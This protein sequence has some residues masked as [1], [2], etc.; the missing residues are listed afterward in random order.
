MSSAAEAMINSAVPEIS[1]PRP[2]LAVVSHLDPRYGGLSAVVPRLGLSLAESG[3]MVSLAAFTAPGEEYRPAGYDDAGL[4]FWPSSRISWL[5]SAPLRERFRRLVGAAKG[6]HIH[7]IWETSTAVA[8]RAARKAERP[9]IVSAHGMLEPWALRSK[10][11]KKKLYA[12]LLERTNLNQATCLHALTKVEAKQYRSFG[13]RGPIAVI[14]NA[15]EVPPSLSPE[16]FLDA[17][18]ELRGKRLILFLGR[19]HPK[20]GLDLLAG[21]WLR[22][23]HEYPDAVLVLA[24]PDSEGTQARIEAQLHSPGR[25]PN[26]VFAGMLQGDL[27]WSALAAAEC[28]VLPSF[29]EGLSVGVL[30]ALG[31]GLPV[32]VTRACNMPEVT[33][34]HAGWEIEP[35]PEELTQAMRDVLQRTPEQNR[36]TGLN[37]AELVRTRYHPRHIAA[38]TAALYDFVLTGKAAACLNIQYGDK[39]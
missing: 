9:Y 6:L 17:F 39:R 19:L 30:E 2:W 21:A 13:A 33:R 36:A 27:K 7:G 37:G 12:S 34:F 18:P 23:T 15:V 38:Q 14:P 31:A 11:L 10:G 35:D 8:C 16:S 24:G 29:S 22:V 20:K 26:V 25:E 1:V 5:R 28:F 3:H 32:L 4:S